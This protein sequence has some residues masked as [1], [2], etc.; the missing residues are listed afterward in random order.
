MPRLSAKAKAQI[1]S[2]L[3]KYARSGMGMDKACES[4][5]DQPRLPAAER[6]LYRG[7]REGLRKGRSIGEALGS[8]G[9]SVSPLER[10]VV[11]A[12][13]SGG[14][15]EKGFAHLAEYFRRLDRTRRRIAKGLAYPL[16]LV[17]LT[18]PVSTLAIAAFRSFNLD[19]EAPA[20]GYRAALA[21]S[22]WAML[23][24]WGILLLGLFA[25]WFLH[26]LGRASAAVDTVL[27]RV[28]FLGKAR[29]AAALERFVQV[30][31]IFLLAGRKMSEAL[32]GASLASGSGRIRAAGRRGAATVAAGQSLSTA[33]SAAPEAFPGDFARGMA[34]AE[35]AGQ[36]DRELAEWGRFYSESAAES[37][38]RLAEWTPKL[39]YWGVLL[40][41]AFLI[42]RAA[43]AYRDLIEGLLN[44]GG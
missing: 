2:S 33:L 14:K 7:F 13:E 31:E 4:L 29:K 8:A 1:Y 30:F 16:F 42:V 34:A 21:S 3:E 28:P 41:V 40:F 32:D 43:L 36:L 6:R 25:A 35:E 20:G 26:R 12:A 44:L 9:G 27:G 23:A 11:T 15:L 18:I 39:F 19:G 22:G 37:M 38:E 17:H 5:L 10:E 24:L